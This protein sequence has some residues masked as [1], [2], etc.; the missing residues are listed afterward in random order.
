MTWDRS[1]RGHRL[2]LATTARRWWVGFAAAIVT[3][4][5]PLIVLVTPSAERSYAAAFAPV[6]VALAVVV[7]PVGLLLAADIRRGLARRGSA[8]RAALLMAVAAPIYGGLSCAAALM[9]I[10]SSTTGGPWVN[11]LL[12]TFGGLVVVVATQLLGLGLG[13]LFSHGEKSAQL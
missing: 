3:V 5:G 8:V 6:T 7:G 2:L 12:V 9:L 1:G 13:I 11:A 10:G 4:M